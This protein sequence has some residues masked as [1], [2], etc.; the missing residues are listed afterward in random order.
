M[1]SDRSKTINTPF[2][3]EDECYPLEIVNQVEEL[4]A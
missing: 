1:I 3:I 4:I 2:N